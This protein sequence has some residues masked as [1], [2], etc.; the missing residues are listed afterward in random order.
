MPLPDTGSD[1]CASCLKSDPPFAHAWAT[2]KL[3]PPVQRMIHELKYSANFGAAHALGVLAARKLAVRPHLMP[4]LLIPVPLHHAR[5]RVRGYNQAVQIAK[6]MQRVLPIRCDAHIASRTHATT[7]QI[8]QTAAQRQKNLKGA[9]ALR[10]R[11][12]GAH[13]ALLDD[14]MTTGATL[15]ELASACRDAG[16]TKIEAWAIARAL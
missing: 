15:M 14:V 10:K 3:A 12:Q 11:L 13:V 7:D 8:G 2:F 16:A 5:L 6:A 4:D 9:F 1:L